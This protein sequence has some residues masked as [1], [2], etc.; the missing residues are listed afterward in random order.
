MEAEFLSLAGTYL[1]C[2]WKVFGHVVIDDIYALASW[3]IALGAML[4]YAEEMKEVINEFN[5][6]RN[7][8]TK[9]F[10]SKQV[11]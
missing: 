7:Y 5:Y 4:D 8:D 9:Y 10:K 1:S 3:D 2:R 11:A 6:K